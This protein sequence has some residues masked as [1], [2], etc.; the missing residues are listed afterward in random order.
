MSWIFSKT[1]KIFT[2]NGDTKLAND[3]RQRIIEVQKKEDKTEQ[4]SQ[5]MS[6]SDD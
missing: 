1:E 5:D 3:I 2:V 4:E 6:H